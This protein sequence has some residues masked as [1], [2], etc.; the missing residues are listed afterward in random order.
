MIQCLQRYKTLASVGTTWAQALSFLSVLKEVR[1][2]RVFHALLPFF[3]KN[4]MIGIK[5][6]PSGILNPQILLSETGTLE[7]Q[8]ADRTAVFKG[9]K[10]FGSP[11]ACI[12]NYS[13]VII[14]MQ[15]IKIRL[16][17]GN[18]LATT[19]R[20]I[21]QEHTHK[22]FAKLISRKSSYSQLFP[23]TQKLTECQLSLC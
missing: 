1:K 17:C 19:V 10:H 12:Q 20:R 22:L 2:V 18:R 5:V 7:K 3:Y 21:A 23:Q 9:K 16:K 6:I 11:R 13:Q 14:Y 8:S 15:V 4:S